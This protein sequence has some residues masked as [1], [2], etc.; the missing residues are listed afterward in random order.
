[1]DT[2]FKFVP[3]SSLPSFLSFDL[4]LCFFF[5]SRIFCMCVVKFI[6]FYGFCSYLESLP[7]EFY[8]K[9][10][11]FLLFQNSLIKMSFAYHTTYHLKYTIQW[12]FCIFID[13]CN[14]HH[15]FRTFHHLIKKKNSLMLKLTPTFLHSLPAPTPS[16]K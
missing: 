10:C 12:V 7:L 8:F 2:S 9:K 11:F 15:N 14:H 13:I 16:R 6:S 3:S 4:L 5:W 1:M